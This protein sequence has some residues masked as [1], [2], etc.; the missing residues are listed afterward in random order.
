[1]SVWEPC[2]RTKVCH[3]RSPMCV[4]NKPCSALQE[5]DVDNKEGAAA[6]ERVYRDIIGESTGPMPNVEVSFKGELAKGTVS[7]T[8]CMPPGWP[9]D[10][11]DRA[12]PKTKACKRWT[13]TAQSHLLIAVGAD[14]ELYRTP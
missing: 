3:K 6:L 2:K 14:A 12:L 5:F 7:R 4:T 8:G 11:R 9:W 1:M 13:T 10:Q